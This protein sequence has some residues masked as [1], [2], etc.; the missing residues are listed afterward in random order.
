MYEWQPLS[1]GAWKSVGYL[2]E[3]SVWKCNL[4]RLDQSAGHQTEQA[5]VSSPTRLVWAGVSFSVSWS[6]HVISVF[7]YTSPTECFVSVTGIWVTETCF[8]S[9]CVHVLWSHFSDVG[10]AVSGLC[11]FSFLCKGMLQSSHRCEP[12]Y[13]EQ[14]PGPN[15]SGVWHKISGITLQFSL[16][17]YWTSSVSILCLLCEGL[18]SNTDS[19]EGVFSNL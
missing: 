13:R 10:R 7:V 9:V 6:A 15:R 19:S 18:Y 8:S 3:W 5:V 16:W 11:C 17:A 12:P 4:E 14:V 2:G 1:A